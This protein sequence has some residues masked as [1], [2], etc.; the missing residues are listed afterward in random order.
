LN[1]LFIECVINKT[2]S[3]HSLPCLFTYL[4]ASVKK[5]MNKK[6]EKLDEKGK[7]AKREEKMDKEDGV[8]KGQEGEEIGQGKRGGQ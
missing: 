6:E 1:V 7:V 2:L 5:V 8:A 4:Y 3:M